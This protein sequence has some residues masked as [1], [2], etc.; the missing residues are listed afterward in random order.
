MSNCHKTYEDEIKQSS[1]YDED[2]YNNYLDF[3]YE[4]YPFY[5]KDIEE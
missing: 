2:G 4:N 3:Q 1:G 5:K